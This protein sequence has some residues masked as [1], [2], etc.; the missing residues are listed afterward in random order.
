MS[1][2][3]AAALDATRTL[4]EV[5]PD[6]EFSSVD[7]VITGKTAG[8]LRIEAY[9]SFAENPQK[10]LCFLPSAQ[11]SSTP[12]KVPF[13]PRWSWAAA[14][15][16]WDVVSLSDPMLNYA[17]D[18]AASWFASSDEDIVSELATFIRLYCDRRGITLDNVILYGSSM[19][20]FGSL[21]IAAELR[22][23]H[24][25]A[26]VPQLDLLRYPVKSSLADVE[27]LA[28]N[29]RAL[30]DLA[31]E[32]PN[33]TDVYSRFESSRCIPPITIVTNRGDSAFEETL[34]FVGRLQGLAASVDSVG[35]VS[36]HQ[37]SRNE[38][39]AV[40][41]TPFMI[42]FL[43]SV[44]EIQS[45]PT[46]YYP[47]AEHES[48][49]LEFPQCHVEND[50]SWGERELQEAVTWIKTAGDSEI[51]VEFKAVNPASGS[52]KG[53]VFCAAVRGGTR[54]MLSQQGFSYSSYRN[55]G[56]YKYVGL[57]E[58]ISS[59]VIQLRFAPEVSVDAIGLASWD[60]KAPTIY[61]LQ[62]S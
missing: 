24:A 15:A 59:H 3:I 48:Q 36:L 6:L 9:G 7:R 30:A 22:V 46:A 1:M 5:S 18:L 56:Y 11:P 21:M 2:K 60:V 53:L 19:G 40:Q 17:P 8:G 51:T 27:R 38:G 35:S 16:D 37:T 32:H 45:V 25:V 13:Y 49:R 42:K 54:E 29:G 58:G 44:A 55:I 34:S 20:G 14:F 33:R 41:P 62:F 4:F 47:S 26:E 57:G 10:L 52:N 31:G 23:V 50:G 61:D 43:K 28:L 12:P 39:H